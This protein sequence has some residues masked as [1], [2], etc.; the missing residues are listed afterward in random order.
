M[1]PS[2]AFVEPPGHG[3]LEMRLEHR[4]WAGDSKAANL[5]VAKRLAEIRPIVEEASARKEQSRG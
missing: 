1:T 4:I 3:S 5:G 2:H